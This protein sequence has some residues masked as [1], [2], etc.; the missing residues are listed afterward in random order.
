M[1]LKYGR[2]DT[3]PDMCDSHKNYAHPCVESR[4]YSCFAPYSLSG[5]ETGAWLES[6]LQ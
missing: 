5:L 1:I 2:C 4:Y 3:A 6:W